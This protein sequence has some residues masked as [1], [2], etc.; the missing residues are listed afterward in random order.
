MLFGQ[1]PDVSQ[2]EARQHLRRVRQS[3]PRSPQPS[4]GVDWSSISPILSPRS[5]LSPRLRAGGGA[6]Q[7]PPATPLTPAQQNETAHRRARELSGTSYGQDPVEAAD[8][9][10]TFMLP[11]PDRPNSLGCTNGNCNIVMKT[12]TDRSRNPL[13][14]SRTYYA[15]FRASARLAGQEPVNV[16]L[17]GPPRCTGAA[18]TND[19][20]RPY[21]VLDQDPTYPRMAD[22]ARPPLPTVLIY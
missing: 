6:G 20:V 13:L 4:F 2:R 14:P 3:D 9:S 1:P 17:T 22:D 7:G 18:I 15:L 5:P 12:E 21:M 11:L 16:R 19:E 10:H 8:A